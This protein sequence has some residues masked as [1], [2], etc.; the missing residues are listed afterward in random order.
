MA[1]PNGTTL[2]QLVRALS[3]REKR[4]TRTHLSNLK[5]RPELAELFELLVQQTQ[6]DAERTRAMAHARGWRLSSL[7]PG[8]QKAV[9][10]VLIAHPRKGMHR[11]RMHEKL[12][13]AEHLLS[14]ELMVEARSAALEGF[15]LAQKHQEHSY[16]LMFRRLELSVEFQTEGHR[17]TLD[18]LQKGVDETHA[19]AKELCFLSTLQRLSQLVDHV[20]DGGKYTYLEATDILETRVL[21][22][23]MLASGEPPAGGKARNTYLDLVASIHYYLENWAR[24]VEAC[25][26]IAQDLEQRLQHIPNAEEGYTRLITTYGNLMNLAN[27]MRDPE[28]FRRYQGLRSKALD[29][30][31]KPEWKEH[32][33]KAT[34][35][36]YH[37]SLAWHQ[38]LTRQTEAMRRTIQEHLL[39]A[40]VAPRWVNH[41]MVMHFELMSMYFTIGL[42]H[43][44]LQE[45]AFIQ[46]HHAKA[47]KADGA[48]SCV[49]QWWLLLAA[50]EKRDEERFESAY[51]EVYAAMKAGHGRYWP[52]EQV[53]LA[54][55]KKAFALSGEA[56]RKALVPATRI[57]DKE[58]LRVNRPSINIDILAWL[59]RQTAGVQ[60]N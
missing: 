40:L 16:A 31:P 7:Y 51:K 39:P 17:A 13:L 23:P 27:I 24:C 53:L 4:L 50:F 43:E 58:K 38:G 48:R 5:R 35:L 47:L 15:A 14:K 59:G 57:W 41:R 1:R 18:A 36:R 60:R 33:R 28:A 46:R 49:M 6:W 19:I 44:G 42:S 3:A 25:Q 10:D 37:V 20:F 9:Y 52:A 8:L 56:R 29:A 11:Q 32:V 54:A 55:L 2:H 34:V 21:Q 26:Q 12:V 22:H 30:A 45:A